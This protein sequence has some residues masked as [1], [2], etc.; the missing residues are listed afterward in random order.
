MTK[1]ELIE[2]IAEETGVTRTD[3]KLMVNRII[4]TISDELAEG[5][6][7]R[8]S[9]LGTFSVTIVEAHEH[10]NAL[11]GGKVLCPEQ[12]KIRFKSSKAL[13]KRING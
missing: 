1:T 13:R 12:R 7:I 6:T 4:K 3:T 9:E 5:G 8:L 10:Y 2:R 11:L